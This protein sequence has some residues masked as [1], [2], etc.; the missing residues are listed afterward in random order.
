MSDKMNKELNE[1]EINQIIDEEIGA[2]LEENS[3]GGGAL[4]GY[5]GVVEEESIDEAMP[6]D[7]PDPVAHKFTK[8]S[9]DSYT[10]KFGR[11][12]PY[13]IEDC[14]LEL[15]DVP[16][17]YP[18]GHPIYDGKPV[19]PETGM[20]VEAISVHSMYNRHKLHKWMC[21]N[22]KSKPI[23][24]TAKKPAKGRYDTAGTPV[25]RPLAP[26]DDFD[27]YIDEG[28]E[29]PKGISLRVTTPDTLDEI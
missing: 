29:R 12:I 6:G 2:Y 27:R 23:P 16:S 26:D 20:P 18:Q 25:R 9:R 8:G 22:P 3:V 14:D 13:R 24:I 4:T 21:A 1:A 10:D 19:D 28:V 5:A 7:F 17:T 15:K 11:K